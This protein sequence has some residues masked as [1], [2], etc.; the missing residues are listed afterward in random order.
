MF[1]TSTKGE[2][3]SYL[4]EVV[5]GPMGFSFTPSDPNL[6]QLH[7]DLFI[8]IEGKSDKL[9][10]YDDGNSVDITLERVSPDNI[11]VKFGTHSNNLVMVPTSD[12]NQALTELHSHLATD[13]AELKE[14]R[15]KKRQEKNEAIHR[16]FEENTLGVYGVRENNGCITYYDNDNKMVSLPIFSHSEILGYNCWRNNC[17]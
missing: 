14:L 13:I 1:V 9:T 8:F 4:Y 15:K 5:C 6:V 17:D 10:F 16:R 3:G 11:K 2:A 7:T 12:C